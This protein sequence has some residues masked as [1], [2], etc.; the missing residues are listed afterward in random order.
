MAE[1]E[2]ESLVGGVKG[3]ACRH[4]GCVGTLNRHGRLRTKA[5]EVRGVRLWCCP[6]RKGNPGCGRSLSIWFAGVIPGHSVS[7]Q[8]LDCFLRA[9]ARLGGDIQ[10][11][12]QE[13]RTG[14]S[15]DSAYRWV[16]RFV[17]NQGGIR[18]RLCRVRAPPRA[19]S[20]W[21]HAQLFGHLQAVFGAKSF[22]INYQ[23]HFQRPWPM[24]A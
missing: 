5:G 11:A 17:R 21:V 7:A 4:C 24:R 8:A 12:W 22:T 13:A 14:F 16:K 6:R 10:A 23:M 18:S 1:G 15:I 3:L 19:C 9:W 2:L 20:K